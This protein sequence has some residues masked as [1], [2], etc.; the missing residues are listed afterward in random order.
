MPKY[1]ILLWGMYF[2]DLIFTDLPEVPRLGT[3]LFSSSFKLTPGGPFSTTVAMRRLGLNVGW[4]CDFGDD[5]FSRYILE[6]AQREDLDN[7][8]FQ[9]HPFPVQRVSAVFSMSNDRGFISFMDDIEQTSAIPVL[10]EHHPRCLFLPHLHYG[11]TYTDLFATARQN[12]CIIFMDCQS[13]EATLDTPGIE[14]ALRAVDIFAPN[15]TEALQLTGAATI[16]QALNRLA[17]FT[18]LV[19][20]K[21]GAAGAMARSNGEVVRVPA[22]PVPAVDT[23]GAGD[24]FNAGFLYGYLRRNAPLD[25]CL[26]FGNI[27]GGLST[28]AVGGT[29]AAPTANQ[30][31]QYRMDISD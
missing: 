7:S 5:L 30:V 14:A 16:E 23:T 17:E 12:E 11:D 3:E 18:P 15:E 2:C 24:C 10:A 13:T 1:D 8:L 31:E 27:C 20:I 29:T 19:I 25:T 26:Q 21:L 22:I 6:A 9:H 4:M 28:T